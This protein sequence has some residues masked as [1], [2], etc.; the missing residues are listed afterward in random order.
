[1][2]HYNKRQNRTIKDESKKM[3]L[4]YF[5]AQKQLSLMLGEFHFPL[6]FYYEYLQTYRKMERILQ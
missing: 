6:T 3:S 2:L 4:K 5:T 1:M